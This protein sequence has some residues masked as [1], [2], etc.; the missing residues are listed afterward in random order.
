MLA[1]GARR[2]P[3]PGGRR[4]SRARARH[5]PARGLRA[6]PRHRDERW[7]PYSP[8]VFIPLT[9][10]CRD[11]CHY[12]TFAQP[13]RRGERAYMIGGRGARHRARRGRGRAATRRSSR[14]GT[15]RS[16]ATAPRARSWRSSAAT[17]RSSTSR[18]CADLVALRD[19]APPPRQPGRHDPGGRALLRPVSASMGLMLESTSLRLS[20]KGG[21]HFGSPDKLPEARLETIRLA[22]ELA[23]PFTTGILIG[24]GETREERLDALAAIAALHERYGHIQE[25]IVQNFR[26]KPG[27]KMAEH[28]EP[29]LDELLWT[30]RAARELLPAD[31][32]LQVPPNLSYDDFP[33]LLEAG[34]DDW[35]GVS[36]V[37]IDH[38]NPEAPWPEIERL[39]AGDGGARASSWR[40]GSPSTPSSSPTSSAGPI[41]GS[42]ARS[43]ATPTP[44]G[45]P[46]RTAGRRARRAGCRDLHLG[47]GHG[48][49]R[50]A[51]PRRSRAS[52][53]EA[54][55]RTTSRPSSRPAAPTSAPSCRR[56][57]ASAGGLRRR[58]HLRRHAERQLHERLLLPLRLL[59]VLQGQARREPAR[60]AVRRP[61]RGD[62]PPRQ[63][64]LGSRRRRD[65]PPGRH[66]PRVHRRDL[67]R[68]LRGGQG[69]PPRPPRARV[70]GA[71]GLAGRRDARPA[72]R[73]LPRAAARR[74]PRLAPGHGGR[75]PRRRGPRASSARTRSRTASGSRCT[76]PPTAS[77]CARRRRSCS[78]PSRARGAGRATSS[79]SATSS[80]ER[81]AS[82]SSCR[83]PS[84]TWRRRSTSRATRARARPSARRC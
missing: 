43:A 48:P 17:R 41:R 60:E 47:N 64:G 62:R 13:P 10:L 15:S 28:P 57:R 51:S 61:A 49:V 69:R 76:T 68:D 45:S 7:S 18:A 46:A 50:R 80:S 33:R 32:H 70:L 55:T 59:R 8:K 21:P 58:G 20:E 39:R 31:V 6:P 3:R 73:R 63:R 79:R 11:V 22:G 26:A 67:P 82:P 65:L 84:S 37:T 35:G 16:S 78:A 34:I 74:R 14:S 54:S 38:V 44:T 25:V 19:G 42:H 24:I 1:D 36:P 29:S 27:T 2:R 53:D 83:C 72:A 9:K 12:C 77:A 66:P 5:R 23:V 81:A 75:D 52:G 71:R 40:R 30:A 56:G 4:R